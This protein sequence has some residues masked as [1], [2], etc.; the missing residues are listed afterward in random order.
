LGQTANGQLDFLY[1]NGASLAG[2]WLTSQN[3]GPVRDA[4]NYG[5]PG[6]SQIV[7]Q[8][9][10]TARMDFVDFTG[11]TPTRSQL[12]DQSDMAPLPL[13]QGSTLAAQLFHVG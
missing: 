10:A 6:H 12:V 11:A 3:Y 8:D 7:T 9:P 1:M 2:S 5:A 4:T 13:V